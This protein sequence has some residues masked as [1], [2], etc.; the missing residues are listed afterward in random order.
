MDEYQEQSY[1]LDPILEDLV[2]PVADKL[3]S[4]ARFIV[5]SSDASYNVHRLEVVALLLY[6][7]VK[8]RGYKSIGSSGSRSVFMSS[9]DVPL[10]RFFPHEVADLSIALGFAKYL[11]ELTSIPM[12]I[13]ALRY[14]AL[15]W[16]S[17]ICRIPFDLTQFDGSKPKGSTATDIESTAKHYLS[18]AGLEREGAAVLLSRLYVR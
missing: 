7:Y 10:V 6:H 3:R 14:I 11:R 8:F 13:W 2:T 16:L 18:A 5:S 17:L 1:L 15:L 9:T 12:S 4:H